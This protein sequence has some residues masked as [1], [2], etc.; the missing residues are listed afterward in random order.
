MLMLMLMLAPELEVICSIGAIGRK[1]GAGTPIVNQLFA[2]SQGFNLFCSS[3]PDTYRVEDVVIVTLYTAG[4]LVA[5]ICIREPLGGE[6]ACEDAWLVE[7]GEKEERKV[8]TCSFGRSSFQ[9][10][11]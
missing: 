8:R 4:I 9:A 6:G 7:K 2:R 5:V 1:G 10:R 11:R 3:V